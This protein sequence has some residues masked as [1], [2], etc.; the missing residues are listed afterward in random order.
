MNVVACCS[1]PFLPPIF[2]LYKT[3]GEH[4]ETT[5]VRQTLLRN[6]SDIALLLALCA[7]FLRTIL[8]KSD[9]LLESGKRAKRDA[10]DVVLNICE[11]LHDILS[12]LKNPVA[13]P[14]LDVIHGDADSGRSGQ[15]RLR[16]NVKVFMST[17]V[18]RL[19]QKQKDTTS[20][21]REVCLRFENLV[22]ICRENPE[23]VTVL[24][25]NWAVA[26]KTLIFPQTGSSPR[27][28]YNICRPIPF[29]IYEQLS[30]LVTDPKR[31]DARDPAR[32]PY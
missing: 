3:R 12:D 4:R 2:T 5:P 32:I 19:F 27:P 21:W 14:V 29:K 9:I 26:R 25:E 23:V 31:C 8:S 15:E 17:Y 30:L 18:R 11:P 16:G 13:L 10:C 7:A 28:T 6:I 24:Y 22:I 20:R 1:E